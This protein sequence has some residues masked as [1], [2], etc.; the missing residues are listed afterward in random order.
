MLF[1]IV[2]QAYT[3]DKRAEWRTSFGVPTFYVEGRDSRR[4]ALAASGLLR[5][6]GPDYHYSIGAVS[7]DG[8]DYYSHNTDC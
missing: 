5:S 7:P 2:A 3:A 6:V 1:R 4:A 8:S